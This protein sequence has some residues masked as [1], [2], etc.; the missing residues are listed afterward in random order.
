M[1]ET[2]KAVQRRLCGRYGS[3]FVP[4]PSYLKLGIA[5]NVRDGLQPLNGLRH[6]PE[7]GTTG[8]FIW[9]GSELSS[10]ADFFE[11]LHVEHL[12]EWC[13]EAIR[14]LGLAPGWRFLTHGSDEDVWYDAS[15]I[16]Q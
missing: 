11:P 8:W 13:P 1:I 14:F 6:A 15:L 12:K 10:E 9:A 3:D 4:S 2:S 16:L 7:S 5:Q